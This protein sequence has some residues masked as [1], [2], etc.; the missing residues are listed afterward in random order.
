MSHPSFHPYFDTPRPAAIGHRGAAGL[1]PEN[2]LPSF[3]RAL[4][5]GAAILESDVH[6][7]RDGVPVLCHDASVDRTTEARGAVCDFTLAELQQLDAGYCFRHEGDSDFSA[8]G[9]GFV[10]PSLEQALDALPD[11]RFNLEIKDPAAGLVERT[12]ALLAAR[13]RESRTLLAAEDDG[14]MARI[15]TH[16]AETDAPCAV[17]ASRGDVVGFLHAARA[18]EAPPPGPMALQVP[19][20]FAGRPLITRA[21][22][23]H[24]HAHGLFVHVWTI[25]DPDE[26]APLLELGVDGLISDYPARA[27]AAIEAHGARHA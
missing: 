21:F 12:V 11:A 14:I 15:R 8:R 3:E 23:D 4:A 10:I 19:A 16:L 26:M 2:T 24:A 1:V 13:G 7:T 20:E 17:G 9:R 6:G 25:N 27:V 18:G 22:V 5:D